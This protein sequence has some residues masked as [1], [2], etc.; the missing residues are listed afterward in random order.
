M[1]MSKKRT[2]II[3]HKNPDTDSIAAATA[4]CHLKTVQG[5]K[6]IHAA[7][8]GKAPERTAFIFKTFGVQLPTILKDVSPSIGDIMDSEPCASRHN[9]TLLHAAQLMQEN[10]SGRLPIVDDD[11][12]Y[13]GMLSL[14]DLTQ[15]F[16]Q[17]STNFNLEAEGTGLFGRGVMSSINLA[18]T[19]LHARI[20]N[21]PQSA[22][23]LKKINVFVGAMNR[24]S[25]DEHLKEVDPGS[26]AFVV[27]NRLDMQKLAIEYGIA[28]LIVTG[29]QPID[30]EIITLAEQ[31]GV[32]LLQTP[33]DSATAVRRLKFSSPVQLQLQENITPFKADDHLHDVKHMLRQSR[34]D[35]FPVVDGDNRLLGTFSRLQA[36]DE[37][38]TQ[39]VLVDHN[40]MGQAVDGADELPIVE[41]VDHHRVSI[42]PT[43]KPIKITCDSVGAT[44]TL[45]YEMFKEAA[46][47]PP[48]EIAGIL[49]GGI[50]TDTLYLRSPT[51]TIRDRHAIKEL[52][53]LSDYNGA[54]LL[55][56]TLSV[57]S[58]IASMS[59]DKVL[60]ADCKS[61]RSEHCTFA[62]AQIEESGFNNFNN[63]EAELLRELEINLE[64]NR[65]DIACLLVTD[66]IAENSLLLVA[67]KKYLLNTIPYHK[68]KENLFDLPRIVS[69]KKQLLPDLLKA[70]EQ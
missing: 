41:I 51:S 29:K 34:E 14:F 62:V 49:L 35:L 11:G 7:S 55:E 61:Y 3:G 50:V 12:S 44:C 47:T 22:D 57:G 21:H 16:F 33:F 30:E 56:E 8:A 54:T 38:P 43:E 2:I 1:V 17:R 37:P 69:R 53:K 60:D 19:A 20:Y 48:P 52:E 63:S 32:A 27:G 70:F 25:A 5:K 6:N 42:G 15:H 67:G 64:E 65:L 59:P 4:L 24:A 26:I 10:Y 66:V 58:V 39:L 18:A 31:R 45:I 36:E 9:T 28:M 40:E 68:I 46:I 23:E 13:L